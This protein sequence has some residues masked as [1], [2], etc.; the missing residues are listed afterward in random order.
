MY[1]TKQSSISVSSFSQPSHGYYNPTL[2]NYNSLCVKG[3]IYSRS[4]KTPGV[5][6]PISSP[7]KAGAVFKSLRNF[8]SFTPK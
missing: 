2:R 8:P 4:K 5:L 6:P 1:R 3:L 7:P